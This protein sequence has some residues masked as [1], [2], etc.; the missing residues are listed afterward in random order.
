MGGIRF[1][2]DPEHLA[3]TPER[4]ASDL[5][6]LIDAL[7]PHQE[8]FAEVKADG[9]TASIIIQ[10]MDGFLADELS[11]TTP[12]RLAELDL[13]LGIECYAGL[14]KSPTAPTL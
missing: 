2:P 8:F 7:G 13:S 1:T 11:S 4:F 9:G 6:R 10:F 12:A 5:L 3:A 14:P